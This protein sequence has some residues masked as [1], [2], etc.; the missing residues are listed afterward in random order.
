MFPDGRGKLK[1]GSIKG[2]PENGAISGSVKFDVEG[3]AGAVL[4]ATAGIGVEWKVG[5]GP[6]KPTYKVEI[7][8][9]DYLGAEVCFKFSGDVKMSF[10]K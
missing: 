1:S 3:K 7:G 9:G 2:C 10:V 8:I 6:P 4:S 5:Q